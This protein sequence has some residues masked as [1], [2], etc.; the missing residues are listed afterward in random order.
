MNTVEFYEHMG[1]HIDAP[2]HASFNGQRMHEIP[3]ER[4]VGPG[5]VIDV[6]EKVEANPLYAV[7]VEDIHKFE[8][9]CGRIPSNAIVIMNSGWGLKY[10]K[11][12]QV[13]GTDHPENSSTFKFPGWHIDACKFLLEKRQVGS[14]GV[15]TPSTDPGDSTT[16][17]CHRYLQPNQVP[18]IEYVANLDNIPCNGTTIVLGAIKTRG[19]TGGPTRV[20]AL[21]D[22]KNMDTTG[23]AATNAL[24][25]CVYFIA[26]LLSFRSVFII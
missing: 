16:F 1:T 7:T 19:G 3:A 13:F 4:L 17:P 25:T 23:K 10:P 6:K 8:D 15:D 14:V 12:N 22:D 21:I 2:F 26:T 20:L 11:A 9:H 24:S 18:L 5:I